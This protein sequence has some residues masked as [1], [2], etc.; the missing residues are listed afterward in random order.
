LFEGNDTLLPTAE[1]LM[2]I[3]SSMFVLSILLSACL[4]ILLGL[5]DFVVTALYFVPA[6]LVFCS[7]VVIFVLKPDLSVLVIAITFIYA[8]LALSTLWRVGNRGKLTLGRLNAGEGSAS[9]VVVPHKT[10]VAPDGGAPSTDLNV[11]IQPEPLLAVPSGEGLKLMS[12]KEISRQDWLTFLK[13]S[14]NMLGRSTTLSFVGFLAVLHATRLNNVTGSVMRVLDTFGALINGLG[15]LT[16]MA[17]VTF[18]AKVLERKD[19]RL[20]IRAYWAAFALFVFCSSIFVIVCAAVGPSLILD[21]AGHAN[22]SRY[23]QVLGTTNLTL[24]MFV[25][26]FQALGSFY[27]GFLLSFLDFTFVGILYTLDF[28]LVFLPVLMSTQYCGCLPVS[29]LSLVTEDTA[30]TANLNN[31]QPASDFDAFSG[32]LFSLLMHGVV[33]SASGALR[34][35]LYHFPRFRAE[36]LEHKRERTVVPVEVVLPAAEAH[37]SPQRT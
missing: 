37:L 5:N 22:D 15:G 26:V 3:Q 19:H 2:Y 18:L 21:F 30:Q 36:C 4:A 12:L 6:V 8:Q 9:P 24:W 29:G 7:S 10:T 34:L 32:V 23:T 27:D 13:D 31:K 11:M 20:F 1:T 28:F 25:V 14:G 17:T 33:R 35:H 16:A